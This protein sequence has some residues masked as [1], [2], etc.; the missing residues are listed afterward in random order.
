MENYAQ[1][2]PEKLDENTIVN[3]IKCELH[4]GV[5]TALGSNP[6]TGYNVD[7][8]KTWGAKVTLTVTA[9]EKG[10]IAPGLTFIEPFQNAV[11]AFSNGN[12]TSAQSFS[13][14]TGAA[15]S[16]EGARRESIQFTYSFAELLN[17]PPIKTCDNERG[18]LIHSDLKIAEFIEN[19]AFIAGVPGSVG[20]GGPSSPYSV[21]SDEITFIVAYGGS[22]TPVWRLVRFSGSSNSPLLSATRTKTQDVII[23][24]SGLEKSPDPSTAPRLNQEGQSVHS[25]L[26]TG[27]AISGALQAAPR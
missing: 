2:T 1:H 7:W 24:L 11:T 15:A 4:K 26:L 16:A 18:I 23:T 12:V 20:E 14:A 9:D 6:V 13:L 17:E 3:Q 27:Q 10:A 21:F 8:L 22:L 19:K 5:Q 25:S